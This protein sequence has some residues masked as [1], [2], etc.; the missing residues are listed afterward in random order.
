MKGYL[1][2]IR[3]NLRLAL[4]ERSVI[5]FNYFFPMI[6]FFAF[7]Q[8][9]GGAA[10]GSA[11]TRI[12]SMVLVIG[13]LGSGLFGAGMR[14]VMERETG[15]LR[16]YKVTPMT[17][18]PIL[19]SSLVTGWLL[20]L[21]SLAILFGIAHYFYRMP[22]PE[23][24]LSL[25]L[26]ITLGCFAF[27]AIGLIIAAV[28]NSMAESNILIQLLYMPMLF[29]SGATIPLSSMPVTAQIIS[30]FLPAAYLNTGMQHVLLRSH[31]LTT[32]PESIGALVLTTV[33]ATWISKKLFRWEKDEKL[34]NRSKAWVLGVLLPFVAMGGY[35]AWS[36]QNIEETKALEREVRRSHARLI[37]GA[38]VIVGDGTVIAGGSIYLKNGRIEEVYANETPDADELAAEVVEAA[39]KTVLPGLIDT[40]VHLGASGGL[41]GPGPEADPAAAMQR[42]LA[43][44][45]YSG[46]T[47]VTSAGDFTGPILETRKVMRVGAKLGAEVQACGPLFTAPGGYG[48]ERFRNAPEFVRNLAAREF[49]RLPESPD[50]A[51]GM[52][53]ALKQ[54][55]VD[56]IK[57]A[58]DGGAAGRPLPRMD[59]LVLRALGE[60]AAREGLPLIV[61]TGD[62]RD[63]ADAIAAGASAIEHGSA[64]DLIPDSSFLAMKNNGVCYTPALSRVEAELALQ[65]K[66]TDLLSRSLVAQ[67]APEGLIEAARKAIEQ[68]I[69]ERS[70]VDFELARENLRRAARANVTLTTGSDAGSYLVIHG[71]TVQREVRLWVEAGIPAGAAMMA[72]T[73]NAARRMGMADRVGLIRAGYEATLVIVDGDPLQDIGALEHISAVFF[74]GERV[75]RTDLFD[76]R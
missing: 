5:F 16:R 23:R 68:G 18:L 22:W 9:M 61:H 14:S 34:P 54:A 21:P 65:R 64:R 69:F 25:V 43:A 39:G 1:A 50:E 52:V 17:P 66:S 36:R 42:A 48:T 8:F 63:V 2:L 29:L 27:R 53:T 31:G 70:A 56:C 30:Q 38:K 62:S 58:L 44:Y 20:Y 12:V 7:A 73:W 24:P 75:A 15:I 40:H 6:F 10:A 47:A 55:G 28:A 49:T 59:P 3:M 71:P 72:A 35:Q 4:R 26:L 51:R 11:M 67:V 60:Q 46:V 41:T 57:A 45:L 37:R 13:I 76:Q 19:V 32:N 33:L 74:R